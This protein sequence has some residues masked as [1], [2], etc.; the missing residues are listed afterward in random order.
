MSRQLPQP[1]RLLNSFTESREYLNTLVRELELRLSA[2]TPQRVGFYDYNDTATSGAPISVTAASGWVKLT[3]NG[4]GA[5]STSVFGLPRVAPVWIGGSTNQFRWS[6]LSLGDTVD[7]RV[8]VTVTTASPNTDVALA[9]FLGVGSGSEYPIIFMPS[10]SFK[11]AGT[12]Q[13]TEFNSVYMGNALT[14]SNPAEF[15]I[16]TDGN[17]TVVV[18]GWYVRVLKTT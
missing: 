9:L 6:D 15:R 4:L 5:N 11:S 1:P 18:N 13:I 7:I 8:D 16:K 17:A 2:S 14:V 12:Y 10:R 3:N